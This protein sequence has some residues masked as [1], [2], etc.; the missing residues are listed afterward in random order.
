MSVE[1]NKFY[2]LFLKNLKI[3][4]LKDYTSNI[5]GFIK[6]NYMNNKVSLIYKTLEKFNHLIQSQNTQLNLTEILTKIIIEDLDY[7]YFA[8]GKVKS[9]FKS[10]DIELIDKNIKWSSHSIDIDD[11]SNHIIKALNSNK[12]FILHKNFRKELGIRLDKNVKEVVGLP[13][14]FNN[15]AEL[16]IMV[17][18]RTKNNPCNVVLP[19]LIQ[20]IP[21]VLNLAKLYDQLNFNE[22]IDSTTN[23]INNTRFEENLDYE[24]KRAKRLEKS[25]SLIMLDINHQREENWEIEELMFFMANILKETIRNV[26]IPARI[27]TYKLAVILPNTNSYCAQIIARRLLKN[28]SQSENINVKKITLSIGISTCPDVSSDKDNLLQDI[29]YAIALAKNE[30]VKFNKSSIININDLIYI[31]NHKLR[32]SNPIITPDNVNFK[33]N[34]ADELIDY[35][36]KA[37]NMDNNASILLEIISSLA[38]AIDAKDS[39]TRGHSQAV[40]KYAELLCNK[41]G[42]CPTE[43][44]KIRIGALM[45]DIGKIGIPENVLT[46]P[47]RLNDE[48]WEIMKQ[49]PIIGARRIIQ[50]IS[51]LSELIPVVE[52]HHERWDGQGYPY[53]LKKEEIPLGARI[54]SI[55]DAFHTMTTDRPYRKSIG[56]NNAIVLLKDGAGAQWDNSLIQSFL[57]ISDKAFDL[58]QTS[59]NNK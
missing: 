28:V 23:L 16:F 12:K 2:K 1:S 56:Y 9:E 58:V 51:V 36:H 34:L 31:N 25:L 33:D 15:R 3:K 39:Y 29:D 5:G 57:E 54:V 19:L 37:N 52:H 44:E 24:I 8:V 47:D 38:A 26:D 22:S 14:T 10:L 53:H 21:N 55:V 18:S 48:E 35:L 40:S 30:S 6:I 46:K 42:L 20:Q 49:H 13:V 59:H 17:A 32:S 50:P 4:P 7:S 27:N 11:K 45:H 41:I 43:T